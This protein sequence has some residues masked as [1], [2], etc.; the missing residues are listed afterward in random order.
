MFTMVNCNLFVSKLLEPSSMTLL[1]D[2][3]L[4]KGFLEKAKPCLI[5]AGTTTSLNEETHN[6]ES[7]FSAKL[8]ETKEG[9]YGFLAIYDGILVIFYKSHDSQVEFFVFKNILY[10]R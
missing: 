5:Y 10:N 1:N 3:T 4:L 8:L 9:K 7:E 2:E 6:L